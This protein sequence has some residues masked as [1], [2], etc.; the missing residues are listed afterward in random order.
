M[1]QEGRVVSLLLGVVLVNLFVALTCPNF[2]VPPPLAAQRAK[3]VLNLILCTLPL[4]WT[5]CVII[6]RRNRIG[7]VVGLINVVPAICWLFYALRFVVAA[8]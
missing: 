2:I 6:W 5:I 1:R 3:V 4:I 7:W 8:F